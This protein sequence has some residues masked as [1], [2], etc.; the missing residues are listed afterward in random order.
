[1]ARTVAGLEMQAKRY[2]TKSNVARPHETITVQSVI[3]RLTM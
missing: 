1:M 3:A 2:H